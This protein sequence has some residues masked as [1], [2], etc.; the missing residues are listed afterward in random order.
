MQLGIDPRVATRYYKFF[1]RGDQYAF[2]FW[3]WIAYLT[4]PGFIAVAVFYKWWVGLL[5]LFFVTP[6]ILRANAQTA[7][8][9]I[10]KEAKKNPLLFDNL[11]FDDVLL[12][13]FHLPLKS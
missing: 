6:L 1:P 4:I 11:Y 9:T 5:L 13:R 2:S 3:T 8:D 7:R 12:F 10:L